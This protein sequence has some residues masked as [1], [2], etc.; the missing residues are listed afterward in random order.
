MFASNLRFELCRKNINGS[1]ILKFP[2][3][4]VFNIVQISSFCL[5]YN[6]LCTTLKTVLNLNTLLVLE[7]S[8][9][10]VLTQTAIFGAHLFNQDNIIQYFL[11]H[12]KVQLVVKICYGRKKVS[13]LFL[14]DH[15]CFLRC[16]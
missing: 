1:H 6:N 11:L 2:I 15:N 12:R 14:Y 5:P 16:N 8:F 10:N 9:Q 4:H 7:Y 13:H 3:F